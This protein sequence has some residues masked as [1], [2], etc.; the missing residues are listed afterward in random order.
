[1]PKHPLQLMSSIF[2]RS[3]T[4]RDSLVYPKNYNGRSLWQLSNQESFYVNSAIVLLI[5][6]KQSKQTGCKKVSTNTNKTNCQK[7]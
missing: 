4:T 3:P 6:K 5:Y 7:T 1:M 2:L